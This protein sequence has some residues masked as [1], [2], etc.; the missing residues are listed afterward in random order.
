MMSTDELLVGKK[1]KSKRTNAVCWQHYESMK[2]SLGIHSILSSSFGLDMMRSPKEAHA[3][4]LTCIHYLL[5]YTDS[6]TVWP[7]ST[8]GSHPAIAARA[9][10]WLKGWLHARLISPAEVLVPFRKGHLQYLPMEWDSAQPCGSNTGT[11][12]ALRSSTQCTLGIY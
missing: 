3:L 1:N 6:D 7:C 11:I 8:A 9:L 4:Y 12:T 10:C 5:M 2:T